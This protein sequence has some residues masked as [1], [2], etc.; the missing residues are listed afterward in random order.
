VLLDMLL[1]LL[2]E[3]A[4]T[5]GWESLRDATGRSRRRAGLLTGLALVVAGAVAGYVSVLI[6]GG[7]LTPAGGIP[8]ASLV[9]APLG[10]GVVMS[11]V[12][13]WWH[14]RGDTPPP[15]FTFAGG[16]TF[17]GAMAVV[18]FLMIERGWWR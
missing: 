7:R 9:L 8:G 10:T 16:A 3:V 12:G 11:W 18:R 4:I 1:Q 2:F 14:R 15:L 17:A 6:F 5:V 13:R